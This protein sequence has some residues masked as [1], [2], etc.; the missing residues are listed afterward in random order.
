LFCLVRNLLQY[1]F[2]L[3]LLLIQDPSV[4]FRQ[5]Y[6]SLLLPLQPLDFLMF[7]FFCLLEDIVHLFEHF[8]FLSFLLL[9]LFLELPLELLND[10]FFLIHPLSVPLP[11]RKLF[12]SQT[13]HSFSFYILN[14]RHIFLFLALVLLAALL[15]LLLHVLGVLQFF[16]FY[17]P[18]ALH[19]VLLLFVKLRLHIDFGL[20]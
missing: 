13:V 7:H 20:L 9:L 8:I 12:Q 11:F 4:L 2:S 3:P 19:H 5:L 15:E 1:C 10:V 6:V 14:F 17:F 18:P 16:F